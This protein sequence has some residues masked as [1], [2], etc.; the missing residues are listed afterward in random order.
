MRVIAAILAAFLATFVLAGLL[1]SDSNP[2]WLNVP[3]QLVGFLGAT[4]IADRIAPQQALLA[5]AIGIGGT[6]GALAVWMLAISARRAS[7]V[8]V[9]CY[10]IASLVFAWVLDRLH[11]RTNREAD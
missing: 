11:S 10:V 7:A 3:F 6:W 8:I 5:A 2:L 4:M 1:T 9:L